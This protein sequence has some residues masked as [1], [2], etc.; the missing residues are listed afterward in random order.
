M[1][2]SAESGFLL[3]QTSDVSLNIYGFNMLGCSLLSRST[4]KSTIFQTISVVFAPA[5]PYD[6]LCRCEYSSCSASCVYEK[7]IEVVSWY[8][9]L[10]I[11]QFFSPSH[12]I[13][14]FGLTPIKS[15]ACTCVCVSVGLSGG[16]CTEVCFLFCIRVNI[17]WSFWLAPGVNLVANRTRGS[18]SVHSCG[19][20]WHIVWDDRNNKISLS[21]QEKVYSKISTMVAFIVC[22]HEQE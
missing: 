17:T 5:L 8:L 9:F 3:A 2:T 12:C 19:S 10:C 11:V 15:A 22:N 4:N 6:C 7:Y 1:L 14:A 16:T 21:Q 20:S 13:V 18:G